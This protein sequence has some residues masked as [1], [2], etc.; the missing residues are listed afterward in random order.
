MA[1]EFIRGDCVIPAPMMSETER[2]EQ[3]KRYR[4]GAWAN[5]CI[6]EKEWRVRNPVFDQKGEKST[7]MFRVRPARTQ[8]EMEFI[9][10]KL[11]EEMPK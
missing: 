6:I 8:D 9:I 4:L 7:T 3:V 1:S 11:K 2:Q 5:G 10:A